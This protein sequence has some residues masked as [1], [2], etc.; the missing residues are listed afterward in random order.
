MAGHA[1]FTWGKDAEDAVMNN[2]VLE[3]I[4]KMALYTEQINPGAKELPEYIQNKHHSRKH[5]PNAY[6]GQK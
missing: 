3:E 6:Y 1:P 5:G 2:I 4:A